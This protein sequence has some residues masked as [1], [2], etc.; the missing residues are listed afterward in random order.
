MLKVRQFFFHN[1]SCIMLKDNHYIS[2]YIKLQH[3]TF[4][5]A[6]LAANDY[7]GK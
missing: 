2:G 4:V 5:G 6:I 3:N 7:L 1:E